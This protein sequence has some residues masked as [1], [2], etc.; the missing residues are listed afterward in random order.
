MKGFSGELKRR[1]VYKVAV[2]YSV[3]AWLLIQA[4]SILFPTFE[5]PS[6]VMKVFI[7]VVLLGF[8]LALLFAWAFEL[9]PEGL[10]RTEE[11]APQQSILRKTGRKL[12]AFTAALAAVALALLVFQVVRSRSGARVSSLPSMTAST[13]SAAAIPEKSIAVLPFENLSRDP[14]NAFF[15]SGIQDEILTAL[16]KISGL[17]VISR[18]STARYGSSPENL[19]EIARQLGVAHILEGSVQKA[20][21][22]VH[23]N[24]QLIR[25]GTDAH[26]WAQTYDRSLADIFAVEAEVA[27]SVAEELKAKLTPEEK[28]RVER[29]PTENSE[30]YVLYLRANEYEDRPSDLL[31]EEQTAVDL[32]TKAITLDPTFALA[33]ARLSRVLS[34]IYLD[35]QPTDA[36]AS[37]ARAEAEESLRLQPDSGE[38][39]WA[40]GIYL[41]WTQKNYEAALRELEIAGKLL[42]NEGEVPATV[43]YIRRRQGQWRDALR[44]L[45]QTMDRDPRNASIAREYFR[46]LCGVRDWANAVP[47]AERAL[48]LAPDSPVI[49]IDARYVSFWSKGD[50]HP[51]QAAL[52]ELPPSVDPDGFATLTRCDAALLSRDFDAAEAAVS[53]RGDRMII[54]ALTV[55]S[56]KEYLLGCIALAR[57]DA[58]R[59]RILFEKVRPHFEKQT[60]ATPLDSFRHAQLGLLY[61]YLGRKEDAVKEGQRAVELTPETKDALIGPT[62]SGVLAMIYAQVGEADQAIALI[63]RL[64]TTPGAVGNNNFEASFTLQDLRHRWQWDPLRKDQRFQKILA[65][66]EPKTKYN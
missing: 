1:N 42:P 36:I 40:L 20:A 41:Y 62:F 64:L 6:W 21:D 8:P 3:V 43:G 65:G 61:A 55:P 51:L 7:A 34:H 52:A 45:N 9:T 4:A 27:R 39:H 29:K 53:S 13:S 22:K 49:I 50:L 26:V 54:S 38:A 44:T 60:A 5:A 14:D 30:A 47:A 59:A 58:A 57:G 19:P 35:Y 24:L 17:K 15:A 31:E 18:K 56:P 33:R 32:Y 10:K 28:A 63:E 48:A 23:I 11:V 66:P 12:I 2:A 37:R 16:A 46:T 25:A